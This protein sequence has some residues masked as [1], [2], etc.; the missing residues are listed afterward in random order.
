MSN[1]NENA[2]KQEVNKDLSRTILVDGTEEF[3]IGTHTLKL[4]I[5]AGKLVI[6]AFIKNPEDDITGATTIAL[7]CGSTS[8]FSATAVSSLSGAGVY[9]AVATPHYTAAEEFLKLVIAGADLADG[10]LEL[11]IDYV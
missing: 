4:G 8:V 6:G 2:R 9:K 3:A 7:S 1:A 10:T 11:G 5:P